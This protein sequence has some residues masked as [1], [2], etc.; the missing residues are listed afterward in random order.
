MIGCWT[1]RF[2]WTA[3]TWVSASRDRTLK[4]VEIATQRFIDNVTSI[5][6]GALKGGLAAVA[7]GR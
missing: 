6:P 1:R 5:T 2:H 4:L 7:R 3:R